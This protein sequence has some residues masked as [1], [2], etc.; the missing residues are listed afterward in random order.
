MTSAAA[1][2]AVAT[3]RARWGLALARAAAL[4]LLIG[5][6]SAPP[7]AALAA[8]VMLLSFAL[9]PDALPRLRRVLAEPLGRG[10]L[11]FV[12]TL[13]VAFAVGLARDAGAALRG[14]WDWRHLLLLPVGLA[15]FDDLAARRR[16]AL[17]FVAFVVVA[18]AV[19][20]VM[21][22]QG[23]AY[24]EGH[25][26][27]VLL[28]NTVT[29]A[30]A[31]AVAAY[32]A[33]LLAATGQLVHPAARAAAALS[34]LGLLAAL[35]ST[36]TGR[37]GALALLVMAT[38]SAGLLLRGRARWV[39]LIA[40]PVLAASVYVSSPLLQKR[41]EQGLYEVQ[42]AARLDQYT[43]MGI[44]VIIWQTT[45]ELVRQRPLLGTGLGGYPA[46]YA[47]EVKARH[48]DGWKATLTADPHNQ[49]LF[50]WAEAGLLGLAGFV[51]LLVG[52]L[53]Q[54]APAP[55]RAAGVSVLAAWCTTSLFSSHFQT[56]N[57]GHLIVVFAGALL[58]AGTA[59]SA[60]RGE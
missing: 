47:A 33:L 55:Y 23:V 58:A 35:L 39:A 30:L 12:A 11:V 17:G 32:L 26:A 29:Q 34:G 6:V 31:F 9:L 50:L 53:R 25:A 36:Q 42:N 20:L 2:P 57:E 56:F 46:A 4:M 41:F 28:R 5:A 1:A 37:S 7:L 15:V 10:L 8:A 16:L 13:L 43:S 45:A 59:Q 48:A 22:S 54:P 24:K 51:A 40:L 3:A 44:R 38:V 49:Y 19:S 60:G 27:G 52:C 18:A 14:L 21:L